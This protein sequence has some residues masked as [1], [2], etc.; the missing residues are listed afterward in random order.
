MQR[1]TSPDAVIGILL[2]AGQGSRFD[3]TGRLDKLLQPLAAGDEVAV[4]AAP[5]LLA[6]L[7]R[8]VAVVRPN[9]GRLGARSWL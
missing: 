4:A 5:S 3:P 1:K 9:G 2:A 8:V 7:P 6:T